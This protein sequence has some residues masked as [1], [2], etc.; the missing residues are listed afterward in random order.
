MFKR[1]YTIF[2]DESSFLFDTAFKKIKI[3]KFQYKNFNKL[4][5]KKLLSLIDGDQL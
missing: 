3:K 4:F 1:K 5:D 2:L